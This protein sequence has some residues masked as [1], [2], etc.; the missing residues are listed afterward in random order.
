[1]FGEDLRQLNA[2]N[3]QQPPLEVAPC[4]KLKDS[5][6]IHIWSQFFAERPELCEC[7]DEFGNTDPT[8]WRGRKPHGRNL[9]G[10][11]IMPPTMPVPKN[12]SPVPEDSLAAPAHPRAPQV[13]GGMLFQFNYDL[14]DSCDASKLDS[15]HVNLG[16]PEGFI[17]SYQA[18]KMSNN[19]LEIPVEL[20]GKPVGAIVDGIF[21]G[22]I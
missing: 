20:A 3:W 18:R 17:Q 11:E 10:R 4:V 19:G 16:V 9:S 15:A 6:E 21:A 8:A 5:G 7:C 14:Y 13:P 2:A 1:M 12:M 22:R